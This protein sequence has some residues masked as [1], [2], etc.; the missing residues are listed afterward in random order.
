MWS[1]QRVSGPIRPERLVHQRPP[2]VRVERQ[3]L[4][5][6]SAGLDPVA[7]T[8]HAKADHGA[9]M[10]AIALVQILCYPDSPLC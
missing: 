2:I 5:E 8:K 4:R 9:A 3:G 6:L 10:H 7:K 1:E